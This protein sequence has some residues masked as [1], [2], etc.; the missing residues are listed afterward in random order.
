MPHIQG[1][2]SHEK[3]PVKRC[4][5]NSYKDLSAGQYLHVKKMTIAALES[6]L[7]KR[8]ERS[9]AISFQKLGESEVKQH[10]SNTN[11]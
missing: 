1:H 10:N 11:I 8:T 5:L 9:A 7:S 3:V 6:I 2:P 4:A